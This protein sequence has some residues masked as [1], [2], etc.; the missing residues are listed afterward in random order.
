[1]KIH[2]TRRETRNEM[3]KRRDIRFS[4]KETRTKNAKQVI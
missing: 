1:M 3:N 2:V 4:W